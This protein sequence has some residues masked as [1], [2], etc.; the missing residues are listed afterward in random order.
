MASTIISEHKEN[1][2]PS[3]AGF[4]LKHV[5][6]PHPTLLPSGERIEARG[7]KVC[8]ENLTFES[9]A[10]FEFRFSNFGFTA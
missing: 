4:S 9:C 2:A 3:R 1:P 10:C 7:M 5:L 8:F 6:P